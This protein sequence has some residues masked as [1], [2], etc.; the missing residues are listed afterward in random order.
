MPPVRRD[1]P[2]GTVTF[3][4]TDIE[5]ST[6]LLHDLG[7]EAYAEA[8]AEHRRVLRE[9]FS[10]HGG[11]EVDTQGD[12]F[13][14][15]FPTAPGALAAAE[16]ARD[17][18]ERGPMRVRIGI[19]TGTPHVAGEGYVGAD[20]HRA[21]RIAASGHG[22]QVLVSEPTAHL[23]EPSRSRLLVDLGLHRLKDL[24]AP[25]RI[26]QLGRGDF[27]RLKS[28]HQTN[29]PVPAT[30]FL[31]RGREVSELSALVGRDDVRLVTLTGPGGTGKTRLALQSAAAV[32]DDFPGGVWWVPLAPLRDAAL[33]GDAAAQALGATGDLADHIGDTRLLLLLDNFEHVVAAA[34][35]VARL[36]GR[37]PRLTVLVTSREPLRVE[38]EWEYAVDP[39]GESEA[40]AL[41]AARARA[42]RLDSAAN[43][44]VREICARLDNLPLAIEL[45]AARVKVLS[46]QA[47]LERLE[48]RLPVLAG[49]LRDAPERQRTLRATIEW[50]HDLL[51]PDEQILFRRLGAFGG[52]CTLE[53][54]EAVAGAD[55]DTVAALVDKSLVRVR[56]GDR[57]WMLETIRDYA[58]ERLER[59]GEAEQVGRRHAEYFLALAEEADRHLRGSPKEWLDRLEAEHDNLRAAYD[60]LVSSGQRQLVLRLVASLWRFWSM[61][62]HAA[63]G[64]RRTE[65][66]VLA[67]ARPTEARARALNA[68]TALAL[69]HRDA[70]TARLRAEE[71]LALD[72][73]SGDRWGIAISEFLL[74]QV[75]VEERDHAGARELL[76]LCVPRFR[77]LGDEHYALLATRTLAWM[78]EELGDLERYRA[79][80]EDNLRR[81][82]QSGNARV[83]ARSLGALALLAA[84]EGRI[85]DALAMLDRVYRMDRDVGEVS[86]TA[87]DLCRIAYV[88]AAG[89]RASAAVELLASGDALRE[90]FGETFEAWALE[91]N[92]RTL[93][94]ARTHL[95]E[96]AFAEA[97]ERGRALAPDDAVTL[98]FESAG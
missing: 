50:S 35:D 84:D 85:E 22:G 43:G 8:L 44:A 72:R 4:F 83:E 93:S 6:R 86:E 34:P 2:S 30:P 70:A 82:R 91:M 5:G 16:K 98:A 33:V 24:S 19:H 94:V 55:L 77:E 10:R 60:S 56:D 66:A 53:A 41:F 62:G 89:R 51:S 97:W 3:L 40:V 38:G 96:A 48:R 13:F 32:A 27:P 63:E 54:A 73:A 29:L 36:L 75:V 67:D 92:D 87:N 14:V 31:G 9:A 28:L 78:Y 95:D 37:C 71:A 25:E 23:L 64:R 79:L 47:L 59:S 61:R 18:L 49:G 45:A 80:H 7:P 17:A 88:L 69:A 21:A 65:D 39:L 74:A 90:E 81:A 11:I 20:V 76:E 52:G 57:Y 15:A 68:A 46:P 58:V 1:L 42:A 12:A 26:Y